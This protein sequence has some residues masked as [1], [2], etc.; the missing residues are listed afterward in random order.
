MMDNL[1]DAFQESGKEKSWAIYA[2][3]RD[4]GLKHG[5]GKIQSDLMNNVHGR[6]Q[7]LHL[8]PELEQSYINGFLAGARDAKPIVE[9]R[10]EKK[11]PRPFE[12]LRR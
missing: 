6:L 12:R 3:G 1:I 11:R 9:V 10:Q 4:A 5:Y 2:M 7:N 8:A